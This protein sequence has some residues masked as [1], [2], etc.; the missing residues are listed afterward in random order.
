MVPKNVY[1]TAM[2]VT[3]ERPRTPR[4]GSANRPDAPP[5]YGSRRKHREQ[6]EAL[7]VALDGAAAAFIDVTELDQSIDA[8]EATRL[9]GDLSEQIRSLTRIINLLKGEPAI[10]EE[11]A[12][13]GAALVGRT[14]RRFCSSAC[15]QKAYR[16]RRR[17]SL[18]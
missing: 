10:A 2:A 7:I 12:G 14:D 9:M 17:P 15:R 8:E 5:R 6:I 3:S 13:C 18:P 16:Q 1:V 11:C 4:A